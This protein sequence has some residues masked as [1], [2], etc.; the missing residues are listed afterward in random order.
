MAANLRRV[1]AKM[2]IYELSIQCLMTNHQKNIERQPE[3][4]SP[5]CGFPLYRVSNWGNVKSFKRYPDGKTMKKNVVGTGYNYVQLRKDGRTY[6]KR[7][8][9][10][11]ANAFIPQVNGKD[12]VNHKD[13]NKRNDYFENLEWCTPSENIIHAHRT[14]LKI[15]VRGERNPHSKLSEYDV[16][17]IRKRRRSGSSLRELAEHYGISH[18]TVRSICNFTKWKH[19]V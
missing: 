2:E 17:N 14:G 1:V 5:I 19:V 13:G 4:W 18:T 3:Q 7:I 8:A 16:K 12:L 6:G 15:G 10:L 9:V 11:V